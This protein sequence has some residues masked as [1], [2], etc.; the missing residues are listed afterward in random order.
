MAQLAPSRKR[1]LF[2]WSEDPQMWYTIARLLALLPLKRPR[3]ENAQIFSRSVCERAVDLYETFYGRYVDFSGKDVLELGAGPYAAP[4]YLS[5]HP[6]SYVMAN[7]SFGPAF[8]ELSRYEPTLRKVT[9]TDTT[10]PADAKSTDL[11]IS[12]N[13][14]EHLRDYSRMINEI[15]RVLRPGGY[16]LTRFSPLYYSPYGAHFHDVTMLPWI[17]LYMR[18]ERLYNLIKRL[19]EPRG[20]FAYQ[21]EQYRTLN[22]QTHDAFIRPFDNEKWHVLEYSAFP[23]SWA[24]R[25]PE[26]FARLLT[27]GLTIAARKREWQN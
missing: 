15:H 3:S 21:W 5:K 16:L 13:T 12:E 9:T 11:I 4:Y 14:F 22:R 7:I 26:P 10:I 27:H 17:H 18:E 1:P 6:R 19:C 20:D 25:L 23:F 8:D 24:P 2:R